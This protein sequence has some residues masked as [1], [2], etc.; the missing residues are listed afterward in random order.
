VQKLGLRKKSKLI[1]YNNKMNYT[2]DKNVKI[3]EKQKKKYS[4]I[5]LNIN[6]MFNNS[7]RKR[8]LNF[9]TVIKQKMDE[10][11]PEELS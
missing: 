4:V 8:L 5:I 7:P 10:H 3:P 6:S 2:L 9:Y 1:K 11:P